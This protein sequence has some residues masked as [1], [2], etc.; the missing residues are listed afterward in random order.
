MFLEVTFTHIHAQRINTH[1]RVYEQYIQLFAYP[2]E[3]YHFDKYDRII[4]YKIYF[5]LKTIILLTPIT[6]FRQL[7]IIF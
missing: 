4:I 5:N 6:I 3:K 1:T 7:N 2:K